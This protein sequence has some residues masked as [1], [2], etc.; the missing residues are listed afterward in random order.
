MVNSMSLAV[1]WITASLSCNR[2]D[3]KWVASHKLKSMR[4]NEKSADKREQGEE[5]KC[6]RSKMDVVWNLFHMLLH[7][8]SLS[9]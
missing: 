3:I 2:G 5:A 7:T 6:G 9:G 4:M 1:P 8:F